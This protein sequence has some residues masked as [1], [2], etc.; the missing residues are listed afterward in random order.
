MTILIWRLLS[1][2]S[3][4]LFVAGIVVINVTGVAKNKFYND[5][6]EDEFVKKTKE[7]NSNNS[8]YLT[9]N[10]TNKYIKRYV[11]CESV[12]DKYLICNYTKKFNYIS[13][14]VVQYT[15]DKKPISVLKCSETRTN[16]SSKIISLKKKC[17]YVNIII[18]K[19]ENNEI[20]ASVMRPLSLR[21]IRLY[22][23]I[24]AIM[25]FA[26]LFAARQLVI[27]IIV[28][29]EF[30]RQ[31]LLSAY[32]YIIV[33]AISVVALLGWL[34]NIGCLRKKNARALNGGSVEYEFL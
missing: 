21:R 17:A 20:N 27:E 12:Y 18:N 26:L 11:I 8:L 14:F 5:F 29:E 13:F 22:S 3:V 25:V 9:S 6:K 32:N 23:F 33:I 24:K 15:K 28:K 2:L 4:M 10:V 19:V 16:E 1:I 31:F 30:L 34:I 7:I